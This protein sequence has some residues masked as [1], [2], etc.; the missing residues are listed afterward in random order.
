MVHP[1]SRILWYLRGGNTSCTEET[2]MGSTRWSDDDY[3]DRARLRAVT[4]RDA[5]EH[6]HAIRQGTAGRQVPQKM[7]PYGV[8]IR[9]SRDS[10]APP[11]SHAVA[12]LMDVTGSM[13][14]VPRI[15]Q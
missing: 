7:I 14:A 2:N 13:Q 5:F 4:G 15:L 1:L 12:V 11:E 6:D 8:G 10:A 9:K 3:R